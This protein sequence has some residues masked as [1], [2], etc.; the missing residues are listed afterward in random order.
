MS[1]DNDTFHCNHQL[2][3][4]KAGA[5]VIN[6]L[7]VAQT[8]GLYQSHGI[9]FR[10][11][12]AMEHLQH[13]EHDPDQNGMY[14]FN[15][16]GIE[17]GHMGDMGNNFS[18]AHMDFFKG[19]DVLLALAGGFPVIALDELKRII[20]ETKPKVVIPMHFRTLCYIP[21]GMFFINEFLRYFDDKDVDFAFSNTAELHKDK[22]PQSTR[23][24]VIDYH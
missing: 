21:R 15:L 12:E 22:L 3:P 2:V 18:A 10:A 13:D 23:A 16:D 5:E 6:A 9:D 7:K 11:I 24:L 20:D 1:S 14:R 4:K 8:G 17:F 19:V